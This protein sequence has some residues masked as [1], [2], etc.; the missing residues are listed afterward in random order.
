[1]RSII[2]NDL[3]T[4]YLCGSTDNVEL[5][6]C[7]HGNKEK[8]KLSTQHHLVVGLCSTCHRGCKGVHGKNGQY[9]DLYLKSVAQE[10]WIARKRRKDAA[11]NYAQELQKWIELF[12]E[13]FTEKFQKL[14]QDQQK[15]S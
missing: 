6:H 14:C 2:T 5:H 1:M 4:C 15:S 12:E 8:R 3:E 10:A 11:K 13:N 9:N 7:I